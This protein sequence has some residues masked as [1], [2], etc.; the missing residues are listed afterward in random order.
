MKKITLSAASPKQIAS[1]LNEVRV[2]ASVA[3]PHLLAF[4]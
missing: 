3:H 4:K 2:L 1:T